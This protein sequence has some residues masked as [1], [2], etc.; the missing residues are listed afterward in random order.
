V[1]YVIPLALMGMMALARA[2]ITT[3]PSATPLPVPHDTASE[4]DASVLYMNKD[5]AAHASSLMNV[6]AGA[7]AFVG[8]VCNSCS[9]TMAVI[10]GVSWLLAGVTNHAAIEAGRTDFKTLTSPSIPALPPEYRDMLPQAVA[11]VMEELNQMRGYVQAMV[12]AAARAQTA[13]AANS[14][15]WLQKQREAYYRYR[16][17]YNYA[18]CKLT[19]D[20]TNPPTFLG[21]M[22]AQ[23]AC[24]EEAAAAIYYYYKWN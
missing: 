9:R 16:A 6:V 2:D 4:D 7:A 17:Q 19:H 24:S 13:A 21:D 5:A 1:K 3:A 18:F 8:S 15:E 14:T 23:L 10:S 20:M 12:D 22:Q 11:R